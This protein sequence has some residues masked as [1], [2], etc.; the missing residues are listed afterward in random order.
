VVVNSNRF[1]ILDSIQLSDPV[2][3]AMSPNLTRLAVTNNSSSTVS[4][5]D[6]NPQSP[7]FDTVVA[8]TRLA[9][10]ATGVAWQP[11][12]EDILVVSPGANLMSIISGTDYTV[13]RT[14][15]GFLNA[16]I[17]VAVTERFT[18]NGFAQ[19]VYYA[20]ILNGNGT[21]AVYE[22]GPDG[23][24]GIGFN[25][26]IGTVPNA[27]FPRAQAMVIDITSNNGAVLIGHVDDQGLGQVSRLELTTSPT[28]PQPLNPNSGGFILPPTYRQKEWTV[29]KRYGGVNATTPG[30][31]NRLTGN[32]VV[33]IAMDEMNNA[34]GLNG[35]VTTHSTVASATPPWGH[36]AKSAVKVVNG[37]AVFPINPKLLFVAE[38]DV[39]K[40]D[41]FE[42]ATGTL[43]GSIDAPG[44]RML[45][46][47]WRQ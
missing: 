33:D 46:N 27:N 4:F 14:V 2:S 25:D 13:R 28:N 12:G 3:M 17:E 18:L 29:T 10:G 45:C 32:S 11:E 23:V 6:I 40:V 44:V 9:G 38:S 35:L 5:I 15:S 39:G 34:G 42:I 37:A 20:Y 21:I 30:T 41:V 36:S 8:E 16:P 31:R 24:N 19:G 22:S 7:T 1:T 47:Y 26:I 43:I